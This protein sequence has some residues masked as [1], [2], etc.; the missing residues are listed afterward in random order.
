MLMR[1]LLNCNFLWVI[2]LCP[3]IGLHHTD[4]ARSYCKEQGRWCRCSSNLCLLEW[5]WACERTG[6]AN[7][8]RKRDQTLWIKHVLIPLSTVST[9]LLWR[10]LWHCQVCEASGIQWNVPSSPDRPLC[11]CW[12]E[13]WVSSSFWLLN[14]NFNCFFLLYNLSTVD[15]LFLLLAEL[16]FLISSAWMLF[17]FTV[18]EK[19]NF[20]A[21]LDLI[22]G[23]RDEWENYGS[24]QWSKLLFIPYL[25]F[26]SS[27]DWIGRI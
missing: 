14:T 19:L 18:M 20:L 10:E 21:K 17:S 25:V 9:V 23:T 12:V 5:A 27:C 1:A 24:Y 16:Q 8:L 2:S 13:F 26:P 7:F 6:T 3:H 22:Q 4:V 11:L 15:D